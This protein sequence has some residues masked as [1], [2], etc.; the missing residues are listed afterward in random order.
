MAPMVLVH[1]VGPYDLGLSL[2][3]AAAFSPDPSPPD[4]VLRIPTNVQGTAAIIEV[5]QTEVAPPVLQASS[6]H[7]VEPDHVKEVVKWITLADLDLSPFYAISEGHPQLGPVT[8]LLR[9]LKHLRPMSIFEMAVIAITEQQISLAAAHHIRERIV[10]R[11][12][13][14]IDGLW[15]FPEP[16]R[17]SRAELSE[18]TSCGL[19]HRKAE[20]VR[21]LARS[22]Y[23]GNTDLDSIKVMSD[24]EARAFI[25]ARRGFG[26]W[27]ADYILI[28]GLGRTDA[29]P[30]DDLVVRTVVG[31]VLGDGTRMTATEVER[32][33]G[34]FRPFRG[35]AIFY[36]LAHA[37]LSMTG[38]EKKKDKKDGAGDRPGVPSV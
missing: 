3:V 38:F 11:F 7:H 26:Q 14:E 29:V 20:Y 27:S 2:R 6:P 35:L 31:R 33:L 8:R 21:D 1:P 30:F 24:D 37:R 18:L 9:G 12:G 17:L 34:S 10:E 15:I 16:E 4:A 22:V 28:R 23:D 5:R 25:V 19:S 32:A 13:R 36:L